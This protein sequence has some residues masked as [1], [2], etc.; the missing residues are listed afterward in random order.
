MYRVSSV[1]IGPTTFRDSVGCLRSCAPRWL[2]ASAGSWRRGLLIVCILAS[3][4]A[5]VRKPLAV[6]Q[7]GGEGAFVNR[8]YPL[9][10]LFLYNFGSYIEWPAGTFASDQSPFVIG[11]L[12]S[13]SLDETLRQ[14]AATKK[15]AGRTIVIQQYTSVDDI[16]PCEILFIARS[17]PLPQ[18]RLA[19]EKLA[20]RHVL[21]VGESI[22]FA[23]DGGSVNFFV[24]ANK[25]RFEI[26]LSAAK[27]QQLKVSSKLLAMA[28]IIPGASA[29]Q[30]GR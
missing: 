16:K 8:E 24:E 20:N 6:A 21:I 28:R 10:A 7:Q 26:N 17:V 30:A 14:I 5:F 13:A 29:D 22:G 23:T 3:C 19:I 1:N 11:V 2:E 9:K 27:Q 4:L 25:I 12:G 15:I 18:Q